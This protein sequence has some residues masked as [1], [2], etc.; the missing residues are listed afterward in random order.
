LW[1]LHE[2]TTSRFDTAFITN[3]LSHAL[4][5]FFV[6]STDMLNSVWLSIL[7]FVAMAWV[8]KVVGS[9]LRAWREA[10][11]LA[12]ASVLVAVVAVGNLGLLMFYYWGQLD[13]AL[14]FRLA[15]PLNLIQGLA[16]AWALSRLPASWASKVAGW[17]ICG[18][19]LFYLAFG[20]P[21]SA[22]HTSANYI[23]S[24]ITWGEEWV[25]TQPPKSR[26][27]V[28]STTALNWFLKKT[29]ALSFNYAAKQADHI[30]YHMA[31]GT[32]QEVLVFQYYRP[33]GPDGGFVLDPRTELPPKFVLEPLIERLMG[34]KLIRISRVV[35]IRSAKPSADTVDKPESGVS[36]SVAPEVQAVGYS[37]S[38]AVQ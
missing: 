25:A 31:A 8:V 32:F 14:V 37:K 11:P 38:G 3:N 5:Y 12:V 20:S 19:L 2:N 23:A 16:I 7:G 27:I 30:A 35:E 17:V 18:G 21:A 29:A 33:I 9:N 34:S 36:V 28:V 1:D 10:S 4:R 15:L 24:E 6:N 13:D 22:R 26:L